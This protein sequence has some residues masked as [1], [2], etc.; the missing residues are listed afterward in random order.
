[1]NSSTLNISINDYSQ[2]IIYFN[3]IN[4]N[5]N[6]HKIII[7]IIILLFLLLSCCVGCCIYNYIG[8]YIFH[9]REWTG[10]KSGYIWERYDSQ[11]IKLKKKRNEL[12]CIWIFICIYILCIAFEIL[13]YYKDVEEYFSYYYE[14]SINKNHYNCYEDPNLKCCSYYDNCIQGKNNHLDSYFLS[15][16][17]SIDWLL[18]LR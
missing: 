12:Y 2:D 4:G 10:I 16:L 6:D 13:I 18:N 14:K 5:K 15:S 7:I 9:H 17:E 1:M 3:N 8:S 11:I